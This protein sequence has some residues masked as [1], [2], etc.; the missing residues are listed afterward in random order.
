MD[1]THYIAV[2]AIIRKGDKFLICK[3]SPKEKAFPN[4]WCVPGGKLERNDFV[5]SKK[6]TKDHWFGVFEKVRRD[7]S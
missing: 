4:K 5:N 3:R 1:K 2:T 6:D 7:K